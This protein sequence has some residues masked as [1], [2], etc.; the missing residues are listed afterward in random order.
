MQNTNAWEGSSMVFQLGSE[1]SGTR[2]NFRHLN[3]KTS[4]CYETCYEGWNFVLGRSL[5]NYLETGKGL[6]YSVD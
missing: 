5:K 1:E 4:P 3:Y 6:P 2:L